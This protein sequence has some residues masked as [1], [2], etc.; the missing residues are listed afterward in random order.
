MWC[1][2]TGTPSTGIAAGSLRHLTKPV[3]SYRRRA[4]G[5]AEVTDRSTRA[6][7][8]ARCRTFVRA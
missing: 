4:S 1:S 3:C 8:C 7:S 2:S 6:L 5:A